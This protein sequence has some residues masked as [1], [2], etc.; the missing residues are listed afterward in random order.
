MQ[1]DLPITLRLLARPAATRFSIPS[2]SLAPLP[3]AG[4]GGMEL[5]FASLLLLAA[6]A[7]CTEDSGPALGDAEAVVTGAVHAS[8]RMF[9]RSHC[10]VKKLS[11][12]MPPASIEI[13]SANVQATSVRL[14]EI[15]LSALAGL[16][17]T[18][19]DFGCPATIRLSQ[20]I[21]YQVDGSKGGQQFAVIQADD[22]CG[23]LCGRQYE[24]TFARKGESWALQ[25]PPRHMLD[26]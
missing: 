22:L 9:G 19:S 6:A 3:L 21:F 8:A 4:R 17:A 10:I 23:P 5:R 13:D 20:P 16:K 15:P 25:E 11:V 18:N 7:A 2:P 26:Y 24:M 1:F 14:S 12:G